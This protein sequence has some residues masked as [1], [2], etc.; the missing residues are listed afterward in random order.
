[1]SQP[2]QSSLWI[3]LSLLAFALLCAVTVHRRQLPFVGL[4]DLTTSIAE[5]VLYSPLHNS[6]KLSNETERAVL[7]RTGIRGQAERSR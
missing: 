7:T 2:R 3:W 4:N 5:D 1:M 6:S